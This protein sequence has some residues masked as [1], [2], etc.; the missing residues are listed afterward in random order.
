MRIV[1]AHTSICFVI[2]LLCL[3]GALWGQDSGAPLT[4]LEVLDADGDGALSAR[5]ITR[6]APLIR[7]LDR[8]GDGR[9]TGDELNVSDD[10]DD[11]DSD[12]DS[13]RSS[14]ESSSSR[15]NSASTG[16]TARASKAAIDGAIN[17]AAS[18]Y[19]QKKF[20]DAGKQIERAQELIE[21]LIDDDDLD[22]LD[23]MS[24]SLK[25]YERAHSLLVEQGVELPDLLDLSDLG[26]GA[27][28][29]AERT[30]SARPR[31]AATADASA[32][33]TSTVSFT[34]QIAPILVKKCGSCHVKDNKA[35][36]SFASYSSLMTG[37]EGGEVV[38]AGNADSSFLVDMVEAG[39]MPPEGDPLPDNEVELIRTWIE[40]GAVFDG[41]DEEAAVSQ[42]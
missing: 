25:R 15:R 17:R 14:R 8:N 13:A 33:Q 27:K 9:L 19:K 40:E 29:P 3:G 22:T 41:K 5:E 11:A 6:S 32:E 16:R 20:E 37:S 28:P 34:K 24:E 42:K 10:D 31:Q 35:G 7:R 2:V 23:E 18:F 39:D 12:T 21:Q 4:L 30:S 1:P 26:L 38:A 36:L